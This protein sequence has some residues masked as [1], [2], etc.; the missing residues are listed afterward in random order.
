[1]KMQG[2]EAGLI[3]S[4]EELGTEPAA[5][6]ARPS[7]FTNGIR[8]RWWPRVPQ[9]KIRRLYLADAQGILDDA[10]PSHRLVPMTGATRRPRYR[11]SQIA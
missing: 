4:D 3:R 2:G 1:M 7:Q 11:A 5:Q 8:P 6:P 9:A 10:R